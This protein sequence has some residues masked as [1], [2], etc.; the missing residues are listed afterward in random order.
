MSDWRSLCVADGGE[1]D[2][3]SADGDDETGRQSGTVQKESQSNRCTS[4]QVQ[5]Q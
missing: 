5:H 3:E 1:T 2:E 4:R